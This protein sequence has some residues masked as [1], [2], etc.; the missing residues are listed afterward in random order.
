MKRGKP[1]IG[2]DPIGIGGSSKKPR[3]IFKINNCLLL[4]AKLMVERLSG[5]RRQDFMGRRKTTEE[6]IIE[7][8]E[9]YGDWYDC[10]KIDYVR[11]KE[12][13][14]V[15]CPVHGPFKRR[16]EQLLLNNGCQKCSGKHR[17]TNEEFISEISEIHNNKYDC[18][19]VNFKGVKHNVDIICPVH[20]RV[21]ML[22]QS[23]LRGNGC[24]HC[25]DISTG[26]NQRK[27][28]EKFISD[29]IEIHGIGDYDYSSVD[30]QGAHEYVQIRCVK[31]DY[32]WPIIP[33]N[34]LKGAGCPICGNEKNAKKFSKT[35]EQFIEESEA[36]HKGAF[37]Y[38]EVEYI[39]SKTN[40]WIYCLKHKKW[41]S[42][43][44]YTHLSGSGCD[45]CGN[46]KISEKL[47]S[48]TEEF[49]SKAKI[50]HGDCYGYAETVYVNAYT[51]VLI[52]CKHHRKLFPQLPASHLKGHGCWD[53]GVESHSGE[54]HYQ[55]IDGKSAE[56]DKERHSPE[57]LKWAKSVKK[58]KVQCECCGDPF[59]EWNVSCA[60]HLN[61]W[62]SCPE[63]RYDTDNGV[64]LCQSCHL[65]FHSIYGRGKNT[66]EQYL[67][68]E[69]LKDVLM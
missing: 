16:P 33:S 13:V 69:S 12:E 17:R 5:R 68:F 55:Y 21:S 22:A 10:S 37:V 35:T 23:L 8:H 63:Q 57:Y 19:L 29:S 49:I 11:A 7:M 47:S 15:I 58:D 66:K 34:H 39:N 25:G 48:N 40:V 64:A 53:C 14:T 65:L 31:H 56:R 44:P 54:N 45:E 59:E 46:E 62:N 27:S 30:Y 28:T 1:R 32:T 51:P 41:F 9:I 52:W 42:Q 38:T 61:A 4:R 2:R 26:E 36:I 67:Q 50:I 3:I 20:G 24:R 6:F 43:L 18:S 60:H